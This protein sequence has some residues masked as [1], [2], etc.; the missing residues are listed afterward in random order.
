ME[1]RSHRRFGR[2]TLGAGFVDVVAALGPGVSMILPSLMMGI[3]QGIVGEG[4]KTFGEAIDG[5]LLDRG[6]H[7]C[8]C[9]LAGILTG[10][11][12]PIKDI[13]TYLMAR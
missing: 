1:A 11:I 10:T 9:L 12:Y 3:D 8:G 2:K 6:E 13:I 4:Q 7:F 5:V